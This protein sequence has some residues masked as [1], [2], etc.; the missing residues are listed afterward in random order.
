M[1]PIKIN[2]REKI[3]AYIIIGLVVFFVGDKV[4][5]SGIRGGMNS[6]KN[7]IKTE[8]SKL[9]TG[10]EIQKRKDTIL[11]EYKG[12]Q[13][14]LKQEKLSEVDIFAR[15]LK[16]LENIA[17][18][19]RVSILSLNPQNKIEESDGYRKYTADLRV[20]TNIEQLYDFLYRIQNSSLLIRINK[21]SVIPKDESG[22]I[23]RF[24]A[25]ISI[26]IL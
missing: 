14:F 26:A 22:T 1:L 8:E 24:E 7:R 17:R 13:A 20:E 10:I 16:E 15:F 3:L 2:K 23:L 18:E 9:R 6:L 5:L 11:G 4:L 19:S 21:M 25:S 12:Y